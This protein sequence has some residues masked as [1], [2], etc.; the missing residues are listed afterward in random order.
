MKRTLIQLEI[1]HEHHIVLA[2]QRARLISEKIGFD[3]ITQTR[4]STAVSEITR[5]AYEYAQ[6]GTVVFYLDLEQSPQQLQIQIRDHG[7]GIA[8]LDEILEGRYVSRTG[9]GMGIIGAKRLVDHFTIAS[10]PGQGTIVDIAQD[11]PLRLGILTLDTITKIT[12]ELLRQ[13]PEDLYEEIQQQNQELLRSMNELKAQQEELK[14]LNRELTDTNRGL[15]SLH[16]EINEKNEALKHAN[17][18]QKRFMSNMS[19]EFR[20]PLNTIISLTR[21]LQE[22]IDGDLTPEQEKQV[23]YIKKALR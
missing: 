11:I 4:I 22:R 1:T 5:N 13:K 14:R 16:A 7:N 9:M 8:N 12:E 23:L 15:L 21:I 19:H 3:K 10:Q 20:S 6:G 18:I 17:E 2:R